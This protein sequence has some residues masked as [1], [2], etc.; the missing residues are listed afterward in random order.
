VPRF[1][2]NHRAARD[3]I[4]RLTLTQKPVPASYGSASYHGEHAFRFTAADGTSRFGRYRRMPEAG[5]AYLSPDEAGTRNA[6]VLLDER[7]SRIRD[8][9]VLFRLVPQLAAEADQ[10]GEVIAW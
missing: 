1:L 4:E 5:D 8:G 6:I 2:A 3:F 7:E 9:P 10:A